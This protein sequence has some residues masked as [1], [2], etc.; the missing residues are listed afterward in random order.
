MDDLSIWAGR[1]PNPWFYTDLIWA[2]DL[3]F[4][5][6]AVNYKRDIEC[7]VTGFVTGGAFPLQAI[8]QVTQPDQKWLLGA[9]AGVEYKP[10]RPVIAKLGVALYDYENTLGVENPAGADH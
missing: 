5:G 3:N 9:Q 7:G 1:I 6:V 10:D 8:T 2:N 4:E